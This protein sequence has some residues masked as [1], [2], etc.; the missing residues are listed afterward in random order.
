MRTIDQARTQAQ[1]NSKNGYAAILH[2]TDPAIRS[3]EYLVE[4][5]RSVAEEINSDPSYGYSIV[6]T[7][8]N[9]V[10]RT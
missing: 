7:Y 2:C 6:E 8:E 4:F 10:R 5:N 9:G 1:Q 3:D